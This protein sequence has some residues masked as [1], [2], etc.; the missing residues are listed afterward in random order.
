MTSWQRGAPRACELGVGS[1]H[2][3]RNDRVRRDGS[4]RIFGGDLADRTGERRRSRD[5]NVSTD[6]VVKNVFVT[7]GASA[8]KRDTAEVDARR[9]GSQHRAWCGGTW[10]NQQ[11]LAVRG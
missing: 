2:V 1:A 11:V 4:R 9:P 10:W 5:R 3:N 8:D 7:G 6:L